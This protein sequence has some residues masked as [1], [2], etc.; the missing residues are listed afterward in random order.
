M[1][2]EQVVGG[3]VQSEGPKGICEMLNELAQPFAENIRTGRALLLGIN[4]T[5]A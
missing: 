3:I 5:I 2:E 4:S 1:L